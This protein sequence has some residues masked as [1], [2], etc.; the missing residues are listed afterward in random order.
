MM[1][2]SKFPQLY[3]IAPCICGEALGISVVAATY[4]AVERNLLQPADL[5]ILIAGSWEG[6]CLGVAQASVLSRMKISPK[7]WTILTILAAVAGYGLSLAGGAG[8]QRPPGGYEPPL[9]LLSALGA[10]MGIAMGA[11]MGALQWIAA[12]G[13][14]SAKRWIVAN[15][16]GWLPA[17]AIIVVAA[18]SVGGDWPLSLIAL[19]GAG[20]GAVAG[21]FVGTATSFALPSGEPASSGATLRS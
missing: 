6:L 7:R 10:A 3:W 4:A 2:R 21:A 5:W 14:I 16:L 9:A 12:R 15:A 20:A 11:L 17:M 18:T 1:F 8:G 13:Q 19:V